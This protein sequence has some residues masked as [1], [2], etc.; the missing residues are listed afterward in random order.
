MG[1]G[2]LLSVSHVFG[3][4]GEIHCKNRYDADVFQTEDD[5][6]ISH[7]V[8]TGTKIVMAVMLLVV[9]GILL[10]LIIRAYKKGKPVDSYRAESGFGN[11]FTDIRTS[12]HYTGGR[13][14]GGCACACAC[15]C[16]EAG[17]PDARKKNFYGTKLT[18][19][20]IR[21]ALKDTAHEEIIT[22]WKRILYRMKYS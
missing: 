17:E 6:K 2:W 20:A 13:G 7:P 15:A 18:T 21:E 22:V 8:G 11:A 10:L 3:G 16:A 9:P 12:S 5:K 1:T 14:S 4:G 19:M